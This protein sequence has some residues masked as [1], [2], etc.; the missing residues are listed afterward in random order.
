MSGLA[1][2]SVCVGFFGFLIFPALIGLG[3]GIGGLVSVR[4]SGGRRRGGGLAVFG[5]LLSLFT[6]VTA[7]V[8]A[9]LFISN[10]QRWQPHQQQMPPPVM[11]CSQNLEK[12]G[13]AMR[14]YANDHGDI[15]PTSTNW[16]D[17]VRDFV[18]SLAVFTCPGAPASATCIFAMNE[19]VAGMNLESVDPNTVLLFEAGGGWNH[20]GGME[21]VAQRGVAPGRIYVYTAG[22]RVRQVP[23]GAIA[24][25]RWNP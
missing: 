10:Q 13:A 21:L 24:S 4:R 11:G 2:A 14:Q 25:Q 7:L 16:C 20:A 19:K 1:I 9:G 3:L 8:I 22:G 5:M 18:P 15:L 17:S 12:L 23:K 6:A